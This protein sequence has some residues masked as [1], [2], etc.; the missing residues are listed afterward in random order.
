MDRGEFIKDGFTCQRGANG[1]WSV[2]PLYGVEKAYFTSF[3]EM[4]DWLEDQ[5]EG[6]VI[7]EMGRKGQAVNE[8]PVG[9][10]PRSEPT[11]D[12]FENMRVMQAASEE[13]KAMVAEAFLTK[14]AD[15]LG[16][17]GEMVAPAFEDPGQ[18]LL[19]EAN[20]PDNVTPDNSKLEDPEERA[21]IAAVFERGLT[22]PSG[23]VL[24]VQR[25]QS[26]ASGVRWRSEKWKLRR[27]KLF[28]RLS[29]SMHYCCG[30]PN[31][32]ANARRWVCS[33]PQSLARDMA[34]APC[35]RCSVW[36]ILRV[37][38]AP[39]AIARTFPGC[40]PKVA[41]NDAGTSPRH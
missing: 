5:H 15:L 4:C 11:E 37:A 36:Q 24:P 7:G 18:W 19:K 10:Y 20:L 17:G 32:S 2:F 21:R 14:V 40:G 39:W 8:M 1:G 3:T 25:W 34:D 6:L 28:G 33:T 22:Q 27:G 23:F 35:G 16:V 26:Q 30:P 12:A 9:P 38:G 13:V 31:S 29:G 41:A